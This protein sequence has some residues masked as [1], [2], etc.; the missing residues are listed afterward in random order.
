MSSLRAVV[1]DAVGTLIRPVRPVPEVYR[2]AALRHGV[3]VPLREIR[4]RFPASLALAHWEPATER[5]HRREWRAVVG[6]VFPE[7]GERLDRLFLDLWDHFGRP[8]SWSV[9]P[10][11]PDAWDQLMDRSLAIAIASNLDARLAALCRELPPLDRCAQVFCSTALGTAKPNPDFFRRVAMGL[12]MPETSLV[13]VGDDADQDIAAARCAGWRAIWL[14]RNQR[15]GQDPDRIARLDQLPAQ[16]A[17]APIQVEFFG[18]PRERA[19]V[20]LA[21]VQ[22]PGQPPK[23]RDLLAVLAE[24]FPGFGATCV[25]GEQ[26]REEYLFVVQGRRFSR[27]A[28]VVLEAYESVLILSADAGG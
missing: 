2:E 15:G 26:L 8:E 20:A 18:I 11:V 14:D 5:H 16:L 4:E 25:A 13:M 3:D 6:R 21:K 7:A 23:L 28:D 17:R 9:Y 22:V 19:G 12:G 24:Q 27:D 10:D 1:F